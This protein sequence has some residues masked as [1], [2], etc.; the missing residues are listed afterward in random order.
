MHKV[1]KCELQHRALTQ[2]E[3]QAIKGLEMPSVK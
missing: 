1:N 2:T 3:Q